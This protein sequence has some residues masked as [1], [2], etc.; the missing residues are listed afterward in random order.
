MGQALRGL[1]SHIPSPNLLDMNVKIPEKQL[2]RRILD[3]KT[4]PIYGELKR[5]LSYMLQNDDTKS[6]RNEKVFQWLHTTF[7]IYM[8]EVMY[9][10]K[11]ELIESSPGMHYTRPEYLYILITATLEGCS[12][13]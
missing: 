13:G 6:N 3:K 12:L 7:L 4:G 11:V 1:P 10:Q 5:A 2:S 9:W 8:M